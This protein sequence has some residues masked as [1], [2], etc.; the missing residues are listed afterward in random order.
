MKKHV[1][2]KR[3]II[4]LS[5][6][7]ATVVGCIFLI[8]Y[9]QRE[10]DDS[11]DGTPDSAAESGAAKTPALI[12][13]K[14]FCS[15]GELMFA[16]IGKDGYLY[17]LDD[18]SKP[19]IEQ[20]ADEL[21]YASDDTVIYTA[22]AETDGARNGRESVIQELQIGEK[23]NT[24]NTIA[25][26]TIDP[27]W[28]S[29]DEVVYFIKDDNKKQLCTFEPLTST[30]ENA[31]EF[32]EEITGLR[33]SS[34]GLLATTVSGKELL[35]I[36][37][38][39]Q[40]TNPNYDCQGSRLIV[41]EQYDL[42][43]T[44]EGELSYRWMGSNEAT[45]VAEHVVVPC[46]YQDNEILYI[47]K[48]EDGMSLCAYFVSEEQNKEL[49]KLPENILPQ[50]TVSADYAF[51]IDDGNIVYRLLLDNNQF[52]P[53]CQIKD[54]VKNPMIS[55]FDYR[56]MVYDLSKEA[57]SSYC[58]SLD[59]TKSPS[60]E[61]ASQLEKKHTE[62]V[63]SKSGELSG[64]STL[65]MA[66]VGE[67][68]SDLQQKLFEAGYLSSVPSGIFDVDTAAA[69]QYVQ[70]DLGLDESGIATPELQLTLSKEKLE[71]RAGYRALSSTSKGIRVRDMQARLRTLGYMKDAVTGKV[72]KP[73]ETA[74]ALFSKANS[75]DYDGGVIKADLQKLLFDKSTAE[76]SGLIE[77]NKGDCCPAA[78]KL[79]E[80][81]KKLG[82]LAGSVNPCF[83]T[84]TETALKLYQQ[85]N[86][87]NTS[88]AG[89]SKTLSSLFNSKAA[90]CPK[91]YAPAAPNDSSSANKGQAISDRQLKII[92]KWL[93]KQFAV[94][95]TDRQAVKRLQRQLV[96]LGFMKAEN[97]TM[98]YD[99][100]T[101]DAVTKYQKAHGITADGFAS[102]STLTEIFSTTK[103]Q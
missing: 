2:L 79:N 26:V 77:L 69:V 28:S 96:K 21:L 76:Y 38:S 64:F 36:P 55:M 56:L 72:D 42:I 75:L 39:K 68:V 41:C 15:C 23:E 53:F 10:I 82:Y 98:I 20:P 54:G 57:G 66:S 19:L 95:H 52:S 80:R 78:T 59:A 40:L 91:E 50:L 35:Y 4:A 87:L 11:P 103:T 63:D 45:K 62:F 7:A 73:T 22:P 46:G 32:E 47:Q 48:N 101:K 99:Q 89:D 5:A 3:M 44:P 34:D 65:E 70:S 88:G 12:T 43:L 81:L 86:N 14:S 58:Y 24:L 90:S 37:L 29:N 71:K 93:T 61:E 84:K 18:E 8:M 9:S 6:V 83:D 92:R 49:A 33:I 94:N 25:T 30:T 100:T 31:A 27:C 51:V 67:E 60:K 16:Y 17:N 85:L 74:L 97:V 102:K 13:P 1:T